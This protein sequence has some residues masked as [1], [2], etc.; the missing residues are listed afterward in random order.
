MLSAMY[1]AVSGIQANGNEISVI[2]DNIANSNTVGFKGARISFENIMSASLGASSSNQVGRGVLTG[3][4]TPI[5]TQS[6][7]D[8]T[9]NATDL[10]IDGDGFFIVKNEDGRSFFTRAGDFIFSKSG[11][12]VNTNGLKVQGYAIDPLT[13]QSAGELSDIDVTKISSSSKST[14]KI[15]FGLNLNSEAE[16]KYVIKHEVNDKI[17][18]DN[19]EY[20]IDA[21]TYTGEAL[22]SKLTSLL[23]S[24]D[25]EV[26]YNKQT[27]KFTFKNNGA[28]NVTLNVTNQNFTIGNVLGFEI[29]DTNGD[30]TLTTADDISIPA[31]DYVTSNTTPILTLKQIRI[32]PDNNKLIFEENG[33]KF[34]A[35]IPTGTYSLDEYL[36]TT[37]NKIV[38]E[39]GEKVAAALNSAEKS[40]G[41][42]GSVQNTYSVSYDKETGK[43]TIEIS[44]GTTPVKF[45]W[46]DP[47]SS[48]STVLGFVHDIK[49]IENTPAV[50]DSLKEIT[51]PGKITSMFAPISMY[52]NSNSNY[53][54]SI[55]IYDSL[56][57]QHTL[58]F[59]FNKVSDNLWEWHATL[60]SDQLEGAA[61]DYQGNPQTYEVGN[62]GYL[63]FNPN[64]S[65]KE[66]TGL[67]DFYAN[68]SGGA[69]S[70]QN[71][72]LNFGSSTSA[73]GTGLDGI[74]QFASDSSTFSENQDGYPAGSLSGFQ[75]S[76]DG[77]ISGVYTNGEIIGLAKIALAKFKSPWEL[78]SE[79]KNLYSQ[80]VGSGEPIIGYASTGGRGKIL[81]NALERSNV[82]IAEEFV[83][84]ITAQR[85]YQANA[86]IITTADQL[87]VEVVNLKR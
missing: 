74:T 46:N 62:G 71:I 57:N 3:K 58:T 65:L 24:K 52:D 25:I 9:S 64:G 29:K 1:S 12:L 10:A 34:T 7:F 37:K 56:G 20:V 39:F 75:V 87:L 21:G 26:D 8:S 16:S 36:D 2:G 77:T 60:S 55:N 76:P 5:F 51:V 43:F 53:S 59:Y 6:S 49:G 68:F 13:N 44:G 31:N 14:S 67:S 61:P 78:F 18:V 54:S 70:L 42:G 15:S 33:T 50:V 28:A 27:G 19:S 48:A 47:E 66:A 38:T 69:Q 22:A 32:T 73:G 80:T 81:S 23:S 11:K 35:T 83:K 41:T 63:R 82:D 4:I 79:G 40:D 45:N 72:S 17:V 30:D 85:A 84:M 86:R